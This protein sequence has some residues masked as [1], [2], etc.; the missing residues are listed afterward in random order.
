MAYLEATFD[1]GADVG[2][3]GEGGTLEEAFAAGARSLFSLV[4]DLAGVEG[5]EA[6]PISCEAGHPDSLFV[7]W[8]NALLAEADVRGMVF[9]HFELEIREGWALRGRAWG[10]RFDASRHVRGV[11]VEGAT[12]TGLRLLPRPSG[13]RVQTVVAV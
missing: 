4:L 7:A 13:W 6:V 10:E 5:R 1:N 9:C 2:V 8:L 11:E 3:V 12:L